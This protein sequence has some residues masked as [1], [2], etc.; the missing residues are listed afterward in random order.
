MK[1]VRHGSGAF[2]LMELLLGMVIGTMILAACAGVFSTAV[3]SWEQGA[4]K[5]DVL[6]TAQSLA[7]LIE[8]HLRAAQPPEDV[9]F[10]PIF[11]GE[12]LT[13]GEMAGHRLTLYSAA[14]G[15]FPRA[16]APTDMAEVEFTLDPLDPEGAFSI[17]IDGSPDDDSW[18]GGYVT[19]LSDRVRAF[20]VSYYDGY[21]WWPDW[22]QSSLPEAVEFTLS[23]QEG[24]GEW[25]GDTTSLFT[26]KRLVAL[27]LASGGDEAFMQAVEG[28]DEAEGDAAG[29]ESSGQESGAQPS[30]SAGGAR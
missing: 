12:D 2:T 8:R 30:G 3:R 6:Q 10:A 4:R 20:S 19:P 9:L 21:E 18:G 27:P 22:F 16:I 26:L 5:T 14:P 13:A 15:R 1:L 29:Q 23:I 17:R 28:D 7:D 11:E 25:D 24:E